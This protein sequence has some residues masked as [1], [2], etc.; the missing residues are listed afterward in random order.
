[1]SG[2]VWFRRGYLDTS[3]IKEAKEYNR[4]FTILLQIKETDLPARLLAR[5][6]GFKRNKS[7][8]ERLLGYYL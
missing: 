6:C 8:V 2:D 5:T 7:R 3:F 1:V 4:D